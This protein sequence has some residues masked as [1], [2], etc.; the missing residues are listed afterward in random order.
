MPVAFGR[1]VHVFRNALPAGADA[2]HAGGDKAPADVIA[3][4]PGIASV[5]DNVHLVHALNVRAG[6][7][8][9]TIGIDIRIRS[10]GIIVPA[11]YAVVVEEVGNTLARLGTGD[12][13][14]QV[15]PASLVVVLP[16]IAPDIDDVDHWVAQVV[17]AL[18]SERRDRPGH[19]VGHTPDYL[20]EVATA[21]Q[22][23]ADKTIGGRLRGSHV[24]VTLVDDSLHGVTADIHDAVVIDVTNLAAVGVIVPT[25]R[26][27]ALVRVGSGLRDLR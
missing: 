1:V 20:D 4:L 19:G 6:V 13:V 2:R 12:T 25:E 14:P 24:E 26:A 3:V 9:R 27:V 18:V 22:Y 21:L 8:L 15:G 23:K 7:D 16:G 10:G 11:D 17:D 5:E